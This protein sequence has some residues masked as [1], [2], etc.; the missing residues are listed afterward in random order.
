MKACGSSA[1]NGVLEEG[2]AHW[3]DPIREL[4]P[5]DPWTKEIRTTVLP[6]RFHLWFLDPKPQ[7]VKLLLAMLFSQLEDDNLRRIEANTLGHLYE[8]VCWTLVGSAGGQ[9]KPTGCWW[10]HFASDVPLC[11]VVL[12]VCMVYLSTR[13]KD[14]I[15]VSSPPLPL[16]HPNYCYQSLPTAASGPTN[17]ATQNLKISWRVARWS[18]LVGGRGGGRPL[19]TGKCPLNTPWGIKIALGVTE[20]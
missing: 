16:F 17:K 15:N 19:A 2:H 11:W 9:L 13:V 3:A 8:H 10:A 5:S 20:C 1:K 4:S 7:A 12:C 14:F 18:G 6:L